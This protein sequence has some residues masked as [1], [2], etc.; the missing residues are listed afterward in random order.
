MALARRY[1]RLRP[2]YDT[3]KIS[4]ARI[5]EAAVMDISPNRDAAS[6]R[7]F[8]VTGLSVYFSHCSS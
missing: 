1:Q 4:N 2:A 5:T 6:P 8:S 7:N 3:D